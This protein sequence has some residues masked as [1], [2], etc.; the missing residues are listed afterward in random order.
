MTNDNIDNT[1]TGA[2]ELKYKTKCMILQCTDKFI[3][4]VPKVIPLVQLETYLLNTA[5]PIDQVPLSTI[6]EIMVS[7]RAIWLWVDNSADDETLT[8]LNTKVY[9]CG[10]FKHYLLDDNILTIPDEANA[11]SIDESFIELTI[12][13]KGDLNNDNG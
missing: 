6:A 4:R 1:N 7:A 8:L 13:C 12:K 9:Y 10:N 11:I 3:N 5:I 2:T